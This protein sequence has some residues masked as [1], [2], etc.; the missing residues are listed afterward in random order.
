MAANNEKKQ[1]IVIKKIT[2]AAA[3]GHGGSWKVAFADFMTAMMAFFLVMWLVNQSEDVKKSVADYFSTPSII[4]YNF[5]NFGVELTLEKLFLDLVNEPL[6]AFEQFITPADNKPNIMNLGM[7]KIQQHF[8]VEVLGEYAQNVQITS[9][10]V[11]F[12]IPEEYLFKKGGS[13]PNAEFATIMERVR[14]LVEGAKDTNIYINSELPYREGGRADVTRN[15]AE[16]R[17]D[18]VMNKVQNSITQESVDLYG[19]TTVEKITKSENK[20]DTRGFIKFRLRLKDKPE[21][22]KP[23]ATSASAKVAPV[24]TH[25]LQTNDG[26]EVYDNFIQQLT[27]K[28]EGRDENRSESSDAH[29][30]SGKNQNKD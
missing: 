25:S 26:A 5:S 29:N 19:K 12:D 24:E 22:R 30:S 16:N 28:A 13:D 3:G 4:E 27:R 8:I 18:F 1:T 21:T 11:T 2:I 9:D 20:R 15:I 6:K 7:K 17:L 10:E 14:E 23:A